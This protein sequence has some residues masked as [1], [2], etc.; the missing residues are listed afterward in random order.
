M[1]FYFPPCVCK[2]IYLFIYLNP[3]LRLDF[4]PLFSAS[5]KSEAPM[6]FSPYRQISVPV[7][8]PAVLRSS[9]SS[10]SRSVPRASASVLTFLCSFRYRSEKLTMSYAE[11]I[12]HRQHHH[13]QNGIGHPLP[14]YNHYSWQ[15]AAWPVTGPLRGPL[16]RRARPLVV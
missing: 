14:P 11:Y 9:S 13:Y 2:Y 7:D 12:G 1:N 3:S 6:E 5:Q 10:S 15:R 4:S 8:R 16:P